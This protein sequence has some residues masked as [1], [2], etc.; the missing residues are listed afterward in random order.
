MASKV[1]IF[2]VVYDDVINS[3]VGLGKTDY[4]TALEHLYPLIDKFEAQRK[5]QDKKFYKRLQRDL[6]EGCVM[7]PLTVAFVDKSATD[8]STVRAF[9]EYVGENLSDAYILDG[10]QRLNT[11]NSAQ[12][13]DGFDRDRNIYVSVIVATSQDKLLYRMITLNNGQRP[14]TP[15]HQIEIL[16][17]E[18]FDFSDFENLEVQTE[19]ERAKKTI[20]GAFN[21]GDI[22]KGYLAFLTGNVNN[23]NSRIIDEKM[24]EILVTRVLDERTSGDGRTFEQ[25][26]NLVDRFCSSK[27]VKKWF[28]VTNNLIGF[29]VGAKFSYDYLS[30]VEVGAMQAAL[31]VFEEGFAAINA[32]KVNIGQYRR[33]LSREYIEKFEQLSALDE[34][35]LVEHFANLTS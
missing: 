10:M 17:A 31:E 2:D 7:P 25:V 16:T 15:R 4:K 8:L 13:N 33:M 11:L 24:D 12:S 14:M 6:G 34:D 26:L 27:E 1:K 19:K 9:E 22:S 20:R 5:L 23:E 35:E 21:L 28:K 3:Y 29:S 30:T 18:M 32:S